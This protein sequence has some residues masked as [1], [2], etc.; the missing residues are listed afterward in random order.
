MSQNSTRLKGRALDRAIKAE[1]DK[2]S[3]NDR[4]TALAEYF[5]DV[6]ARRVAGIGIDGWLQHSAECS[7]QLLAKLQAGPHPDAA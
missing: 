3:A 2:L 5:R 6:F 4:E 7:Q 1:L